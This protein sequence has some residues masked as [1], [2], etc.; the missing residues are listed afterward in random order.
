MSHIR[1]SIIFISVF[2]LYAC[3]QEK[4][5]VKELDTIPDSQ[6]VVLSSEERKGK[7]LLNK[8]IDA[9]GDLVKW[10]SFE[11]LEYNLNDKGKIVYQL[12]NLK[13]RRAYLKSKDYVVGFDGQVAWALPDASKVSGK[14]AAFYYNLD[15]YFIGVPFLLK[16]PGVVATYAGKATV[17][18]KTYESLKIT[19][20][21]EVG[22]TP[23]DVYYLYIDPESYMLKILTYSISYFDKEDAK[24]NSAKVYSEYQEVQGLMMPT[25]ME[26][27]EWGDGQM[28]KSKNHIR[29]FSDIKFLTEISDESLFEVPDGAVIEKLSE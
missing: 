6:K 29:L 4:Q 1:Y 28:G 9:H 24:I 11:A 16:D 7:E 13:D 15:F 27:F 17:N 26:N 21:S 3:K 5:K 25:K 18:G 19:F 23:E 20:G 2:C 10:N 22:F 12:T 8:C 14:S